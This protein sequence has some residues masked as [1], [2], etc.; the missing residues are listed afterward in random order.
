M[1][2]RYGPARRPRRPWAAPRL[3]RPGRPRRPPGR[4]SDRALL[5]FDPTADSLHVGHLVGQLMLRRFQLAG[6]RPFPSPAAPPAWSA[7]RRALRGAQPA[8]RRDA[9]PQRR[10]HQGASSSRIA[11]LRAGAVQA[12]LVNNADWTEPITLLEFLRDVGK[13]VTVNQMLAKDSVQGPPGERARA[14]RS[15]SSATCCCRPTTSAPVR[16]P[17]RASS[18]SAARTSGATSSP[19]ST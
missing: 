2:G 7:T 11:R 8:R 3:D 14:S 15:P 10:A 17:R 12:T 1:A 13:H 18:R 4:G 9:A 6:H 16:A 19:A 5:G